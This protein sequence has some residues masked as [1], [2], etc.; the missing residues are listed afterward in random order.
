MSA[1]IYI[2]THKS[3]TGP[4]LP[5]YMP[6]Q[7]GSALRD[8]PLYLK[9]DTGDNI[10]EKNPFYSELTGHYWVWKNDIKSDYVG[11]VH[12]RRY[13]LDDRGQLYTEE[14]IREALMQYDLISTKVITL[15]YAYYDAFQ[16]RHNSY[17]LD[18]LGE[19]IREMQPLYYETYQRLVH[20]NKTYFGNMYIMPK[21]L[22]DNYMEFLFP[23]L[24]ETEKRVDMTGYDGYQKRL[25]GFLS[26]MLFGVWVTVNGLHVKE[27][28]VGMFGEKAETKE[29]KE[30]LAKHFKDRNVAAAKACFLEHYTKRPDILMEVSDLN[31]ECRLAMQAISSME[32]DL[33]R[34]GHCRLDFMTDFY[35]IIELY[36]QLNKLAKANGR[37]LRKR[38]NGWLI[39]N[40]VSEMEYEIAMKLNVFCE[41]GSE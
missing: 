17:D 2:M 25:F 7:V 35:E 11:C 32:W 26:E 14:T 28:V 6:L 19:V 33:E 37:T 3:F 34:T 23:L 38:E 18:L 29:L 20:G 12:Y 5:C 13:L 31:G 9:D 8:N 41:C 1:T 10:S 22:Y 36:R 24:F 16:D 30:A 21:E 40:R 15:D 39:K 4:D 27:S